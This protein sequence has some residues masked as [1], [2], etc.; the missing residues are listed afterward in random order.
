MYIALPSCGGLFSILQDTFQHEERGRDR[1]HLS[2]TLHGFLDDFWWLAHDLISKPTRI[3][4]LI[5]DNGPRTEVSCDA[6][7]DGMGIVHFIPITSDA[8]D[9]NIEPILWR[10]PF[11]Q[12]VWYQ[13]SSFQNPSGNI[14][15]S[16]LELAASIAQ[17]DILAQF[18]DV[19]DQT[20]HNCYNNIAA[21]YWQHKGE[22]TTLGP[23]AFL[24]RLQALHQIF[25]RYVPLR[26]YLRGS[27]DIMSNFGSQ[28]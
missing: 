25:Y 8:G 1:L 3:V 5:W 14:T 22:T 20:V 28:H 21:V 26:D 10:H 23:E 12:W 2:K 17:N 6:A 16:N 4:E 11:P 13:L 15:N 7:G 27:L 18:A 9:N 24:L 19:T